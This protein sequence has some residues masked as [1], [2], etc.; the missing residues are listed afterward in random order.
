MEEFYQQHVRGTRENGGAVNN[1][2]SNLG[3]DITIKPNDLSAST[4]GAAYEPR[5]SDSS[6]DILSLQKVQPTES[7]AF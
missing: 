4:F 5:P 1:D 2:A 3:V 7:A 6:N